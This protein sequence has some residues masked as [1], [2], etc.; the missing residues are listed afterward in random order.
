[1][2]L[3]WLT[4]GCK[5]I[6]GYLDA[7]G[8]AAV[9][10]STTTDSQ[11]LQPFKHETLHEYKMHFYFS[12]IVVILDKDTLPLNNLRTAQSMIYWRANVTF[13]IKTVGKLN[14][15]INPSLNLLSSAV[16]VSL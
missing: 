15:L 4:S 12:L 14:N 9:D 13:P 1:M 8:S 11:Q 3:L 2:V 5:R 7:R 16:K 10:S 6:C